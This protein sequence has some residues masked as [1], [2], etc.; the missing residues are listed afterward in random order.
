MC[1]EYEKYNFAHQKRSR[2]NT[3]PLPDTVKLKG[4]EF[5]V[6]APRVFGNIRNMMQIEPQEYILSICFNKYIEFISN[7]KSGAFFYYSNDGKYLI[8]T[9]EQ[10]EANCLTGML[11]QYSQHL[12]NNTDTRLCRMY[13]LYRLSLKN[14]IKGLHGTKFYF[15]IM[16]SVF[17]TARFIHLIYDLKGSSYGREAT[18]KDLAREPTNNFTCTVLKDNDLR[19]SGQT[20]QIGDLADKM[21]K[22][23]AADARF[24]ASQGII[25]Y[26]LLIGIHYPLQPDPRRLMADQEKR[27]T[28]TAPV[29][30][31]TGRGRSPTVPIDTRSGFK[32]EMMS[33]ESQYD[34]EEKKR[35]MK[36]I[37]SSHSQ[38]STKALSREGSS[39]R[40]S[41]RK[42]RGLSSVKSTSASY[43]SPSNKP[44]GPQRKRTIMSDADTREVYFL[45]IIDIL[46]QYGI[47]KRGEYVYKSKMRGLGDSVSVIPPEK[48]MQRFVNFANSFIK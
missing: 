18:Q 23:I 37:D 26:S 48:Y 3:I 42:D 44:K 29:W 24:L 36:Q 16:E 43:K 21:K 32:S 22:Q 27:K 35:V 9:V 10:A 20:I 12:E 25:D 13:G 34:E 6:Y 47:K 38:L 17:Y 45:G 39:T 11:Y 4:F 40:K 8:K 14:A 33:L 31:Q 15:L 5:K 46:V 41:D 7:S 19:E 30:D 2:A 28:G 1:N